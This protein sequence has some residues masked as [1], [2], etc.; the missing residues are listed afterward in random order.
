MLSVHYYSPATFAIADRK[1]TWGYR[2]TWGDEPDDLTYL[3][4]Q[5][6]KLKT[7]FIDKGIPYD[8]LAK[9]DPDVTLP[10]EEREPGGLGI[11]MVKKSM[12]GVTY[13]RENDENVLTIRKNFAK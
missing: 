5:F 9:P 1:S 7:S 6:E 2:E 4:G 13:Q 12:D 3:E 8:P 10:A 11:F